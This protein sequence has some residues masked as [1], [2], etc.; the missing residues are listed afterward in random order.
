MRNRFAS[1]G[2]RRRF[3]FINN[4]MDRIGIFLPIAIFI[5]ILVMFNMG[6]N[7]LV[8]ANEEEALEAMR[9]AVTRSVVQFYALEGRYPPSLDCLVDRFGLQLDEDRFIVHY[10]S[11]G[12]NISPHITI[13]PRDF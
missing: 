5:A 9:R 4:L 10:V 6:L 11:L 8:Q 7:Q 3:G 13:L 1:Q 2:K 12:S